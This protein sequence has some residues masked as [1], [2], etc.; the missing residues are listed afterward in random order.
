MS[1]KKPKKLKKIVLNYWRDVDACRW[2]DLRGYFSK[3]ASISWPNT[4]ENFGVDEFLTVSSGHQGRWRA[5]VERMIRTGNVVVTVARVANGTAAFHATSFFAIKSKKIVS[6]DEYWGED[7]RAGA[8][9]SA[10]ASPAPSAAIDI[11]P[12][13]TGCDEGGELEEKDENAEKEDKEDENDD[14]FTLP[15]GADV[16]IPRIPKIPHENTPPPPR[17]SAWTRMFFPEDAI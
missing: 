1:L 5:S 7:A 11:V 14:V 3:N 2:D 13:G 17:K 8:R 16:K 9:R 10:G 6:L 15:I 12:A 4:G